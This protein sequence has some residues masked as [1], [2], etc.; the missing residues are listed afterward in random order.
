[1]LWQ[2]SSLGWA[3]DLRG[4]GEDSELDEAGPDQSA[5]QWGLGQGEEVMLLDSA[6]SANYQRRDLVDISEL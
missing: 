3:S 1:M 2:E 5:A 6:H 4:A